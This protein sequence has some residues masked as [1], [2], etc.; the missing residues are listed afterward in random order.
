MFEYQVRID[1]IVDGDTFDGTVDLGF[2][3]YSKQR[4]RLLGYSA[5]ELGK[6]ERQIGLIAKQKLEEML[7]LGTYWPIKS[8]KTE[9][10]GRWLAEISLKDGQDLSAYLIEMGYGFPWNGK[11]KRP[12]FDTKA[13]PVPRHLPGL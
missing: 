4:F 3:T 1:R 13:Y 11:G 8:V 6:D 2:H 7:P 5:P 9:K 12:S 10:F